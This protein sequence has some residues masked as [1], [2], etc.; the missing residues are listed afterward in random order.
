MTIYNPVAPEGV[1]TV[2]FSNTAQHHVGGAEH[3]W[4]GC[5][6]KA[7]F[8]TIMLNFNVMP[9]LQVLCSLVSADVSRQAWLAQSGALP[10]LQRLTLA[11]AA[12]RRRGSGADT[13]GGSIA[14]GDEVAVADAA[15]DAMSLGLR[16]QASVQQSLP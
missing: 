10:M 2:T 5:S 8:L 14:E 15:A 1:S 3:G 4:K 7:D 9:Y 16:K 12:E 13:N 6:C 11:Q